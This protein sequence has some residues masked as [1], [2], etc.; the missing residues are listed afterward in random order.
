VVSGQAALDALAHALP[1]ILL[2]DLHL[3][4]MSG[5][6]ILRHIHDSQLAVSTIVMTAHGSVDKVV[7]AMRLGAHDFI[8]K[9]VDAER[10]KVTIRNTVQLRQLNTLVSRYQSE[11]RRERFE[12]FVGASLACRRSIAP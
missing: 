10:L 1:D 4:D 12:G 6:E 11:F 8:A 7:D 9:P 3:P 5:M 2:L